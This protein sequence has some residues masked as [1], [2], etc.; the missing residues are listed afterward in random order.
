MLLKEIKLTGVN[1]AITWLDKKLHKMG[2]DTRIS[3]GGSV[4]KQFLHVLD[5]MN[6]LTIRVI[7]TGLPSERG[8]SYKY[9]FTLHVGTTKKPSQKLT[10]TPEDVIDFVNKTFKHK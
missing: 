10:S 6:S 2:Y 1:K 5:G 4:S 8:Q 3:T 7:D 9:D